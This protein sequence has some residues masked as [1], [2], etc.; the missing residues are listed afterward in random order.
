MILY[1]IKKAIGDTDGEIVDAVF[2]QNENAFVP[3]SF[4]DYLTALQAQRICIGPNSEGE[5]E[6]TGMNRRSFD[7]Q[8][9][10]VRCDTFNCLEN[11]TD[12]QNYCEYSILAL[13]G[14]NT[15]GIERAE[16][17]RTWLHTK[18]PATMNENGTLPYDFDFVQIFQS[19]KRWPGQRELVPPPES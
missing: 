19:T 14:T 13:S 11:F 16:T 5:Y 2:P 1:S 4:K 9:P 18:Y 6:I 15:G 8:V 7:W 17:F 12:A 10:F 3:L